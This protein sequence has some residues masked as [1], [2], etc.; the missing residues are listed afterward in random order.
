MYFP[1]AFLDIM[2]HLIVHLVRKIKCCGPIYLPWMYPDKQYVKILKGY[3]KNLHRLEA[4]SVER[5]ITEEVI[6]FYS[7]YIEK[8]KS[9]GLPE[10]RHDERVGGKG[11]RGLYVITPSIEDLQQAYLYV[12]NNSN[13]V[14]PYILCHEGLVKKSNPKISKNRVLKEHNKIFL[15]WFKDTIL[16]DDNASEMLRKVT[17]GPKRNVLTWQGY[18]INKYSFHT[19]A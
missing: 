5:Y 1:P 8:T 2:V 17:D 19:K 18:N 14:L 12:L 7:E 9:V 6:E 3:T 16:S 11:S 10:S 4:S 15:T 13:E